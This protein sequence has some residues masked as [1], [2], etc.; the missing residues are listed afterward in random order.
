MEAVESFGIFGGVV[1]EEVRASEECHFMI[2]AY[3]K[4]AT[5]SHSKVRKLSRQASK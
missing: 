3:S 5:R 2:D 1:G 4:G